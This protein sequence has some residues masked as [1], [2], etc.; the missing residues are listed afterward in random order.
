MTSKENGPCQFYNNATTPSLNPYSWNEYANLL[1]V[2]EPIGTGFS[3][4]TETVNGTVEAAPYVWKLLQS[5]FKK[6]PQYESRDF[7]LF[8][9]SYGGHYGPGKVA[10]HGSWA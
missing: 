6:F 7:G 9:E 10:F 8:T 5:F 4:G 2:D 1:Y 3:Y